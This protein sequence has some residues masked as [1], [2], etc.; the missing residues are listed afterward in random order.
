[1]TCW[2]SLG[3]SRCCELPWFVRFGKF[4][5][6]NHGLLSNSLPFFSMPQP[7]FV[8]LGC[9]VFFFHRPVFL[10]TISTVQGERPQLRPH[11]DSTTRGDAS[12]GAGN[13]VVGRG[14]KT[15][16]SIM[17]NLSYLEQTWINSIHHIFL[18][19]KKHVVF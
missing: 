7:F 1:M 12:Q 13:V 2:D 18:V 6:K 17:R 10:S 15:T 9:H 16:P 8:S 19:R 11:G 4:C 14:I 5:I 3:S